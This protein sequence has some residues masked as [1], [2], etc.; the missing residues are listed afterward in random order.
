MTS[1]A[2]IGLLLGLIFIFIIAFVVNGLPGFLRG[3]PSNDLTTEVVKVSEAR[4]IAQMERQI[5]AEVTDQN[6]PYRMSVSN[7]PQINNV[8]QTAGAQAAADANR[9]TNIVT[10]SPPG[11]ITTD[12]D[13]RGIV[14][15]G[16]ARNTS[17][18]KEQAKTYVVAEGDSLASIAIKFY[19][20]KEGNKMA[21]I[22]KI[23]EVNRNILKSEDEI[24]VGQK[25]VIPV[26]PTAQPSTVKSLSEHPLLEKVP[27]VGARHLEQKQQ[28]K[29]G[30]E[31]VVAE[32]DSLWKIADEK[33]GDGN[34]YKEITALNKDVLSSEDTLSVG[35]KLKLPA[36]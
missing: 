7:N 13:S 29:G 31:Y 14:Q 33:L 34:R 6:A 24:Q 5:G 9:I 36:K 2:K 23:F 28:S 19:G 30:G 11:R 20:S 8:R 4:P 21:S 27:S 25:L 15:P 12:A 1:D 10:I 18:A 22:G 16:A 35:M 17:A 32:G 26:L 3:K